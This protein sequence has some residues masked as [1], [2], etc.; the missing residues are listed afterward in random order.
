MAPRDDTD[1][2]KTEGVIDASH[3]FRARSGELEGA[4][5]DTLKARLSLLEEEHRD[6]DDAIQALAASP[7]HD[8]LALARLKKRKLAL[9]DAIQKLKDQM[10][11][12]IIA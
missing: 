5:D 6:L 10:T 4:N 9:K 2:G 12:D 11:P 3:L 8:T 7:A 1:N